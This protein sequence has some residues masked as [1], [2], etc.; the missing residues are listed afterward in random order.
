MDPPKVRQDLYLSFLVID[1]SGCKDPVCTG[2]FCPLSALDA[3]VWAGV[4]A[5]NQNR[6]LSID[7]LNHRVGY[8]IALVFSQGMELTGRTQDPKPVHS[9]IHCITGQSL[10]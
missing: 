3:V 6:H 5:A 4:D 10:K 9:A 8:D 2:C 1:W 7:F